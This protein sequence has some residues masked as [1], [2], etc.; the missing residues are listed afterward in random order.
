MSAQPA[1][2]RN[3]S[4]ADAE[5]HEIVRMVRYLLESDS[6]DPTRLRPLL[7]FFTNPRARGQR[8]ERR[9]NRRGGRALSSRVQ[10]TTHPAEG[11]PR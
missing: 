4:M 5:H 3:P 1:E 7:G 2:F 10:S 8:V 11:E 6:D 9:L